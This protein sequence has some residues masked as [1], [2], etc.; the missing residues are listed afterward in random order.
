MY[1]KTEDIII[2]GAGLTGLAFCNLLKN[3]NIK[4]SLLDIH[5]RT[6]YES[7]ENERHIVLSNSSKSIFESI[8]LWEEINKYCSKV[9]NIHVSKKNIFGSTI[10]KSIDENLESLG[11]QVPV[12]ILM[13]ILYSNIKNENNINF[14]HDANVISVEKGKEI[15]INYQHKSIEKNLISNSLIFSSGSTDSLIKDLFLKKIKKDYKQN[16]VVCELLSNKYNSDTAYER[17]TNK[18]VLGVIPRKENVWTLIY[19]T[20]IKESEFIENLGSHEIKKYFQNLMGKK[21]GEIL[22]INNIKIYPLKMQYYKNFTN[23]NICLLGDA[24]HTLHPIA[25]QSFNLSLRDCTYLTEMIKNIEKDNINNFSMIFDSY[26]QERIKEVNRLVKFTDFLASFIHGRGFIK[27]NLFSASL[28][29]L[30]INK[31]LRINIIRYLL[32]VNFSQTLISNLK[33]Q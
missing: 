21:C 2:V 14:I 23:N 30:D 32:G 31:N 11:Y 4:L 9:K 3:T 1:K 19:S 26:Y 16:A 25:A 27:N 15:N 20:D 12:K 18:G 33:K 28:L 24:A 6:F 10:I 5:P 8:G 22:E 29:L 7:F 17:F 13:Q